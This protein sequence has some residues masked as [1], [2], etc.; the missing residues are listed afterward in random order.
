MRQSA[1]PRGAEAAPEASG[2]TRTEAEPRDRRRRGSGWPAGEARG[3]LGPG[4]HQAPSCRSLRP[5]PAGGG[6]ARTLPEA[7][8]A[9]G[10]RRAARLRRAELCAQGKPVSEKL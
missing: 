7:E 5:E 4:R 3:R 10:G 1:G 2:E 9:E 8:D 6:G